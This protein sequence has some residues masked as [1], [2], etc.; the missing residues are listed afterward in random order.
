[1]TRRTVTPSLLVRGARVVTMDADR[2]VL[3]PGYVAVGEDR[4]IGVGPQAECPYDRAGRVI[5]AAGK[6]VLPGFVNAHTHAIHILMRGGLSDDR[7]LYDWL[8]NVVLPGLRAYRRGDVEVAARLYCLE[9]LRSGITTFVDNVEFPTERWDMAADAA[10]GVYRE[11]GLRVMFARM[12]YDHTPDEFAPVI[13]AMEAKEPDVRHDPG[14][15]EP[16]A[17]ALAAIERLMRRHHGSADGRIQVWPSPGVARFCT[18]EGLL[19]ARDLARRFGTMVTLHLAEAPADR[20]QCGLPSVEY[21]GSIGFLGPDVLAGHC[22]QTDANDIR[23]LRAFD[24]KVANNPVSNL[25]LASG[26]APIAEMQA[27]GITVGL[28]TD[29]GNCNNSVNIVADMKF[30]ALA[31]KGR[32]RSAAAITAEK[33]LEMATIDGARAVGLGEEIGSL[34]RGKKADLLL[35]D[36]GHANLVPCHS[37]ASVLVYQAN[38]T[39]VDTVVVDGRVLLEGRRMTAMDR[40]E[41]DALLAR[42][43]AASEHVATQARLAGFG[44]RAWRS[45]RGV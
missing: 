44:D 8:F 27:A 22:V 37:I 5:D 14:G 25:L 11:A 26:I 15:L 43:Q 36:L 6:A 30:A 41:E 17:E 45:M 12:F 24:V 42:A 31:Q 35:L 10:I 1:M 19:G 29:D 38:G 23:T 18:R 4:I 20:H 2:R 34:E 28:G 3:S 21:L 32:Y 40:G 13:E 16:T 39:E 33:V 7:A 9:A